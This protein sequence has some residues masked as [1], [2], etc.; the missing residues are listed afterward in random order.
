MIISIIGFFSNIYFWKTSGYFDTDSELK[1]FLHTWSLS[2]EEQ[3][4]FF[5]PIFILIIWKFSKNYLLIF[6]ISIF[7]LS[8]FLAEFFVYTKPIASFFLLPTRGWE[9][10]V[11]SIVYFIEKKQVVKFKYP[12][13]FSTVGFF[14]ISVS[15]FLF[16]KET[17]TPSYLT[18][19]PTIGTALVILFSKKNTLINK[20]LS[21]KILVTLGLIS[22][23]LYLWHYPIFVFARLNSPDILTKLDYI[24]LIILSLLISLLSW[25]IIET[26]FRN[27]NLIKKQTLFSLFFLSTAF[28]IVVSYSSIKFLPDFYYNRLD[29]KQKNNFDLIFKYKK[30]NLKNSMIDNLDCNFWSENLDDKLLERFSRCQNNYGKAIIVLGDSHGMNMYNIVS[31]A[32]N[33]KFIVGISKGGCRPHNK[34]IENVKNNCFYKDFLKF[35]EEKKN[36][37]EVIIYNQ[38]GAL[39]IQ[40]KY[41][42]RNY[43]ESNLKNELHRFILHK[44]NILKTKKY[45]EKLNNYVN[46]VWVGPH[47]ESHVNFTHINSFNDGFYIDKNNINL[48]NKMENLLINFLNTKEIKIKFLP[49]SQLYLINKD[50]L[51]FNQCITFRDKDHFSNCGEDIIADEI[52]K[53]QKIFF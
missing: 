9:F 51:F 3:F 19:L 41:N 28:L 10:L 34:K 7:F 21:N 36:S 35:V 42:G 38:T 33:N 11:G 17:F 44:E 18:L 27:K 46:L 22:Y 39:L 1:P 2:L 24:N 4:Y 48:F 52:R 50:F 31:K 29:E 32:L 43:Y 30:K 13:F 45:L 37:I 25:K 40:D 6:I 26:P 53:K 5:F 23:S 15:I 8:F 16:N 12:N 14:F 20:I 49:F 47:I